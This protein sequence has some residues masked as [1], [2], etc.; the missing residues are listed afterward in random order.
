MSANDI[1]VQKLI[2]DASVGRLMD[3]SLERMGIS[4][5]SS[6]IGQLVDLQFL[7]LRS[8]RTFAPLKWAK[9]C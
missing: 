3:L 6:D 4:A 8:N 5:L 2:G 1:E 7:D 9:C